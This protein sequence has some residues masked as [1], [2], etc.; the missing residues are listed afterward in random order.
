M[1]M[2]CRLV[3][4]ILLA[5]CAAG[6]SQALAQQ[7]VWAN[8]IGAPPNDSAVDLNGNV[9]SVGTF[10]GTTDFD[11]GPAT[12]NLSATGTND[13]FV[14]KFDAAGHFVWAKQF[15]G[16]TQTLPHGVAVDSA[17]NVYTVG[18]FQGTVDF[19]PGPG[20]ANL[21]ASDPTNSDV[22]VSKLDPNGNLVWIKQL[23]TST[24]TL[25]ASNA[26]GVAVDSSGN[27]I[28]VGT[29]NRTCDFDPGPGTSL[30]P[31][32]GMYI[33]KL[34][35]AG[36]FVWA[37]QLATSGVNNNFPYGVA[38]DTLGFS[39][40]TG[41]YQDAGVD[42]DPG[43]GVVHLSASGGI[44]L[45][46]LGPAGN[47]VYARDT[48]GVFS[49]IDNEGVAVDAARNVYVAGHFVGTRDFDPGLG[50]FN[51][52][53]AGDF[54]VFI[55]KF[56]PLGAFVW[57]RRLGG[58][59]RDIG[60]DL[61]VD[62]SGNVYTVGTFIGSADFDPGAGTAVL[63]AL[64]A[65]DAYLSKLDTN[66]NFV[67]AIQRGDPTNSYAV[68]VTVDSSG[69]VYTS[70]ACSSAVDYDPGAGTY[71]LP[72]GAFVQKLGTVGSGAVPDGDGV[73]GVPLTLSKLGGSV[74]GLQWG[75][76]CRAVDLDYAVYEGTLGTFTSH[77]PVV[78]STGGATAWAVSPA[79]GS[80]YFLV[81]PFGAPG[82]E[83]SY[84][85]KSPGVERPASV[86]AC[87]PQVVRSC[88]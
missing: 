70:G 37:D 75:K 74:L 68:A 7:F 60:T 21:T 52:T 55:S 8:L 32:G 61:A 87:R 6:A 57:A 30:L 73:A 82:V 12:F 44:F 81:V 66:G 31:N 67:W 64:G 45:L 88:P 35:S 62:S 39:Y 56:D 22:F 69:D 5:V 26:Y 18:Q 3:V 49:G 78:C 58:A 38:V 4:V 59:A 24:S 29:F 54:D 46:E 19:D 1:R 63:T 48:G 15:A 34:D 36:N 83:G 79:P 42:F 28:T 16:S 43:G 85:I 65:R 41:R 40:I 23:A 53:S 9:Y 71:N 80:R 14:H 76:S 20:T 10:A 51:M 17:G 33:S 72:A 13:G 11:P 84:G 25:S 2:Q 27:V 77:V 86:A 50:T 47:F